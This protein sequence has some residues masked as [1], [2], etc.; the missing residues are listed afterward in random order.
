MSANMHLSGADNIIHLVQSAP[1]LLILHYM[2]SDLY[3]FNKNSAHLLNIIRG[4]NFLHKNDIIHSDLKPEVIPPPSSPYRSL[5]SILQN[6][7]I[8]VKNNAG[9]TTVV[10]KITDFGAA[11]FDD[12]TEAPPSFLMDGTAPYM[13]PE[14][15]LEIFHP[16]GSDKPPEQTPPRLSITKAGDVW[17]FGCIVFE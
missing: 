12:P 10:C 1:H 2:S 13:P 5:T 4:I 16:D 14:L 15:S 17:A 6:I 8:E 11:R 9:V 7:L 3:K